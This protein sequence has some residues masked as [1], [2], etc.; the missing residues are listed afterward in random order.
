VSC[1][2]VAN[3]SRS[4]FYDSQRAG[5]YNTG[6]AD[7]PYLL[8][9]AINKAVKMG[10]D[11]APSTWRP[12]V[13]KST[14]PDYKTLRRMTFGRTS[15]LDQIP[16]NA[17]YKIAQLSDSQETFS[18]SKYGK[19]LSLTREAII[20]DDLSEL[21]SVPA[22][23]TE[24]ASAKL[25][26]LTYAALVTDTMAD[27]QVLC[28][29]SHNN[30]GAGAAISAAGLSG[31]ITVMRKQTNSSGD[32][33]NVVPRFLI[34]PPEIEY[35]SRTLVNSGAVSYGAGGS[36][37]DTFTVEGAGLFREL[38]LIV[39]PRLSTSS[40]TAYYLTSIGTPPVELAT[41]GGGDGV[42]IEQQ[43]GWSIDGIEYKVRL[44][45]GAAPIEYRGAAKDAGV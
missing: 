23:F 2:R 5:V 11:A 16:E 40:T 43:P 21:A 30:V 42:S 13:K 18:V 7:L 20:N 36:T 1:G 32:Y 28:H 17:E 33:I 25:S 29:S 45:A 14:A 3:Y 15:N 6:T 27:G 37:T 8:A 9:D 35:E 24:S 38:E 22:A 39:E 12:W 31:L 44:E 26:D 41:I 34:V 4:E 19:I 10:L